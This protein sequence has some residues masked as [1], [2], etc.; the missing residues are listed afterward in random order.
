MDETVA[1]SGDGAPDPDERIGQVLSDRYR[2]VARIGSGGMGVV[3][4]AWDEKTDGY[5]VVKSPKSLLGSDPQILGRFRLELSALRTLSHP[6]IVPIIDIGS[7]GVLPFAVM[8]YL[9]GGSLKQRRKFRDEKPLPMPPEEMWR[10]LPAIARALDF[11]HASGYV[12]RDVK[13]DNILFNGR[14]TPLLS[15]FGLAKIV[16]DDDERSG[17]QEITKTGLAVGTPHY[18]A[19]E[20]ILHS[21]ISSQADQFALAV[22]LYELLAARKPFDGLR[23]SAVLVANAST[24]P[25]SLR[26]YAPQLDDR[27]IDGITR[28]M[29]KDPA[30]RFPSCEAFVDSVLAAVPKPKPL[31]RFRLMCPACSKLLTVYS[32]LAGRPGA[33]PK[34]GVNL[35]IGLDLQS[36]WLREDRDGAGGAAGEPTTL[37]MAD[38]AEAREGSIR[39]G[40][41]DSSS[42][43]S[44]TLHDIFQVFRELGEVVVESTFVKIA[45]LAAVALVVALVL[46]LGPR[47]DAQPGSAGDQP[48]P[49][50]AVAP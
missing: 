34:C 1:I 35:T 20:V 6:G 39:W 31:A 19:P 11:V 8:P 16:L 13:P 41:S 14:G 33:C 48:P 12:H 44:S 21:S 42:G 45:I 4:R 10:W 15:D 36:L 5:V 23:P 47:R 49:A 29:S 30:A 3:Y 32:Q 43:S 2:I 17:A 18:M 38:E 50:P 22:M 9:A 40:D 7:A 24:D 25:P 37:M 46:T 26:E 27:T 28:A